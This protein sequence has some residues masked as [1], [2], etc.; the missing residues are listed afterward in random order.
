[1]RD[2]EDDTKAPR[3]DVV[4]APLGAGEEPPDVIEVVF[5]DPGAPASPPPPPATGPRTLRAAD[6]G[7][8]V[9]ELQQLL[10]AQGFTYVR[11]TGVY[12]AATVRGVT[13]L[14]QDRGLTCDPRGVYG[15]CTRA[16][17]TS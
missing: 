11:V 2:M 4:R 5:P 13:E 17:L 14:Q 16:A 8:D 6:A 12:D 10:F 15:P 7:P 3:R 9:R 1:M